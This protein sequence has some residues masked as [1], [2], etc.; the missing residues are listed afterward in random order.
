M[1]LVLVELMSLCV[2]PAGLAAGVT[3]FENV[4]RA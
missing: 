2:V 3:G 4:S 1:L